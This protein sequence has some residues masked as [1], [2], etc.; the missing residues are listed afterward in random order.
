MSD[1]HYKHNFIIADN[2]VFRCA[3]IDSIDSLTPKHVTVDH[4]SESATRILEDQLLKHPT[5]SQIF[6]G[7]C[8]RHGTSLNVNSFIPSDHKEIGIV[9]PVEGERYDITTP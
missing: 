3:L 1:V 9:G 6:S 8:I 2:S 7:S 4:R 5:H